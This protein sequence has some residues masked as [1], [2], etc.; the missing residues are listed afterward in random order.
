MF[1]LLAL[2][3]LA[4]SLELLSYGTIFFSHNKTASASLAAETIQ[5]TW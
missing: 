2:F 4:C 1:G 5:R 3:Q